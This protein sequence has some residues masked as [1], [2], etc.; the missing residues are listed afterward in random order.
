MRTKESANMRTRKPPAGKGESAADSIR[1][2]EAELEQLR[3][4]RDELDRHRVDINAQRVA[5][6]EKI[7]TAETFLRVRRGESIAIRKRRR[8]PTNGQTILSLLKNAEPKGLLVT[9]LVD[10]LKAAG[11]ALANAANP[12]KATS[13][14][15]SRMRKNELVRKDRLSRRYR[16]NG[17]RSVL[18]RPM[19]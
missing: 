16:I 12:L 6:D 15:L 19:R 7:R 17:D 4:Q 8:C 14:E 9:E 11:H 10:Q 5:L 1:S 2:V 18:A 13:N 3:A